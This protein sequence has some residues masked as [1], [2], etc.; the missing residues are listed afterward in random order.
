MFSK[1][2]SNYDLAY[3]ST[4]FMKLLFVYK[5]T[6]SSL[7]YYILWS[8]G[9]NNKMSL[10]QI[11]LMNFEIIIIFIE[12]IANFLGTFANIVYLAK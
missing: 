4:S 9:K 5:E 12:Y 1:K 10:V 7:T 6:N 2:L 8:R 11:F 3:Q